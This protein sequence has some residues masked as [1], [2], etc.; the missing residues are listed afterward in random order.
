M[1]RMRKGAEKKEQ[2]KQSFF[3]HYIEELIKKQEKLKQ[4]NKKSKTNKVELNI[5]CKN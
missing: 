2:R 1:N 3:H 5:T 4:I